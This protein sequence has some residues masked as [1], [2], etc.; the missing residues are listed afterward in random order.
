[1]KPKNKPKGKRRQPTID[2]NL[3]GFKES[4]VYHPGDI[5]AGVVEIRPRKE[6]KC[7]GVEIKMGWHTE[8]KGDRDEGILNTI[9]VDV[10]VISERMPVVEHFDFRLPDGPWT[11]HGHHINIIWAI[12][13]KID[14]ALAPDINAQQKI[15]LKPAPAS[16]QT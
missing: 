8:G 1:M 10:G 12:E 16:Q 3:K 11:Y 9:E 13:V 4:L 14:I 5:V 6:I 7:R 2:I 15:I